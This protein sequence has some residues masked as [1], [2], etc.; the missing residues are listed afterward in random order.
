MRRIFN[1]SEQNIIRSLSIKLGE[2]QEQPITD[3]ADRNIFVQYPII[4]LPHNKGY[5]IIE[6]LT[7]SIAMN[8]TPFYWIMDSK[9]FN[10][11]I[12]GSI[13][14]ATAENIVYNI[15]CKKFTEK[16][17]FKNVLIRK[18][19]SS[20]TITDIDILV[21]LKTHTWFFK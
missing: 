16:Q 20:N 13:R 18:T 4:E 8:E 6:P 9:L 14:G 11:K 5:F 19:K 7:L 17:I 21:I 3:I 2:R 1:E 10:K 12:V 15:A